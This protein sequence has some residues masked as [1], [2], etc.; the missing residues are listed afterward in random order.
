MLLSHQLL[1]E[2][3]EP[4]EKEIRRAIAGN[5]CRCTGYMNI[6]KAIELAGRNMKGD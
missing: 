5:T 1:S 4:S 2:N 3:P 6:F